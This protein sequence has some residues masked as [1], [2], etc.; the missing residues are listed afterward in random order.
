MNA[1]KS[2][3]AVPNRHILLLFLYRYM[4]IFRPVYR[5]ICVLHAYFEGVAAMHYMNK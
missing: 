1:P 3:A 5:H 4:F 2:A